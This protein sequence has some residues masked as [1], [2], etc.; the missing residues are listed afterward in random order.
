MLYSGE[1]NDDFHN[2]AHVIATGETEGYYADFAEDPWGKF[3][4][5]LAEGFVYQGET[6]PHAGEAAGRAVRPTCR[7]PPSSTSC[8]TTTRSATAPSASG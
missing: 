8:R 4:R 6:S 2:V 1:W 7:P 5:A 3:G